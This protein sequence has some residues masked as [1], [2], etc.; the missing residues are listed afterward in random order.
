MGVSCPPPL[1]R[2]QGPLV[3]KAVSGPPL[4]PGGG[5]GSSSH[6]GLRGNGRGMGGRL[7][8]HG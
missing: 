2:E 7:D 1:T 5:G 4:R 3:R 6:T 8:E